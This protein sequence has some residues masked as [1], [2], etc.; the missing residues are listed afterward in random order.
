MSNEFKGVIFPVWQKLLIRINDN[1]RKYS[2]SSLARETGIVYYY[3]YNIIQYM[4]NKGIIIMVDGMIKTNKGIDRKSDVIELTDFGKKIS[5]EL[6][7]FVNDVVLN[8]CEFNKH[9]INTSSSDSD[10][11]IPK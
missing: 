5:K 8:E 11:N 4:I 7:D 9:N 10:L 3:V 1:C 2:I 6:S